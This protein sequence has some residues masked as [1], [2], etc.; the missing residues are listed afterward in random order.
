MVAQ[1]SFALISPV[2]PSHMCLHACAHVSPTSASLAVLSG[3]LV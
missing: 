1:A 3:L 2:K